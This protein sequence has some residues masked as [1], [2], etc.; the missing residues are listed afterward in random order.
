MFLYWH[1][2][3]GVFCDMIRQ[4]KYGLVLENSKSEGIS[5]LAD[6]QTG[7]HTDR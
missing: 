6:E 2:L 1:K 7:G 3:K 4:V 5:R